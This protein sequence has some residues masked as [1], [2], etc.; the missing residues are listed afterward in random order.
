MSP[1]ANQVIGSITTDLTNSNAFDKAC[2]MPAGD[3]IA[4]AQ[5]A[6]TAPAGFGEA[7]IAFMNRGGVRN[8]GFIFSQSSGG[9][10]AGDVTYG[11]AFTVQPFG[12]SLVTMSLTRQDIKNALEQQFAGCR[13][14]ASTATRIM[15]TSNGL[16]K[17]GMAASRAI[18]G[19]AT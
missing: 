6:A 18:R 14:Q 19:S 5:L 8:P 15:L 12:N 7:V 1:I 11:E 3:L 17:H 4:D 16:N 2:D 10:P 9:E 13:G